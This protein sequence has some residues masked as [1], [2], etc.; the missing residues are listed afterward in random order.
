VDFRCEYGI[1]STFLPVPLA[2][3]TTLD[4]YYDPEPPK[5]PTPFDPTPPGPQG[6]CDIGWGDLLNGSIVF[7]AVGCALSWAFVPSEVAV[8][9]ATATM[10]GALDTSIFGD[11]QTRFANLWT[12]FSGLASGGDCR[13]PGIT[14][15]NPAAR[16]A[17]D[18]LPA[19][20]IDDMHPWAACSGPAKYVSDTWLGL[21]SFVTY[22]AAGLVG[23]RAVLGAIGMSL[24]LTDEVNGMGEAEAR[25]QSAEFETQAKLGM[26]SAFAAHAAP[27]GR[28]ER[29]RRTGK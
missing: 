18:H 28:V 17:G 23:L 1:A 12:P 21:A 29:A 22:F 16:H 26:K 25:A 8:Q 20:L 14:I 5:V 9:T 3:C 19:L 24:D 27:M 6:G 15:A 10:T 4:R 7:K 2:S 11:V 13:G